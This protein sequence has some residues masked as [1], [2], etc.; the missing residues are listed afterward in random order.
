METLKTCALVPILVQCIE[1]NLLYIIRN[2]VGVFLQFNLIATFVNLWKIKCLQRLKFISLNNFYRHKFQ[3]CEAL[4]F[5]AC[6]TCTRENNEKVVSSK[7]MNSH[8]HV[9]V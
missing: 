1:F 9:Q 4:N 7:Y 5:V 8:L 2:T 3:I 6:G